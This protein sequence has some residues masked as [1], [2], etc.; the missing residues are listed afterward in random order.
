MQGIAGSRVR[1]S[2]VALLHPGIYDV[3]QPY[4]FPPWGI[5]C[6]RAALHRVEVDCHAFDLNGLDVETEVGRIATAF[7]PTVW[8]I[9]GKLG[10]GA[11]RL[12]RAID[13]IRALDHGAAIA[14]GGPLASTFPDISSPLWQGVDA[15]LLG[16]GESALPAWLGDGC[17]RGV[18]PPA[19]ADLDIGGLPSD[20][21]A[22]PKYVHPQWDWPNFTKAG[23]HVASARGCT[24]R[25]T[26]CYLSSHAV[27]PRLRF[28]SSP[29]LAAD[30][31]I[32]AKRTGAGGFY[33]VDDC[34][35]DSGNRLQS[36]S[37]EMN[38]RGNP[39]EFGC[40]VQLQDLDSPQVLEQMWQCGFRALYL[41]IEAASDRIRRRL[42]KGR[43]PTSVVSSV[44]RALDL[45]FVVRASIGIGWPTETRAEMEQTLGLI[46]AIDRLA[47]DA[48]K[49]LPLPGTPEWR[50]HSA[51][52]SLARTMSDVDLASADFSEFNDN[53][54]DLS[55]HELETV[56]AEMRSLEHERLS[57]YL[58]GRIL[59]QESA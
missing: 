56:W 24:R 55:D 23:I 5:L 29:R 47:F 54:T 2:R 11:L 59:K 20:W 36:F 58:A 22:L 57:R 39:Y 28:V 8:G 1:T 6:T 4:A 38:R 37:G 41:G 21:P 26:F 52:T 46:G 12:R 25:C 27:G 31:D 50:R 10:N 40:D 15:L 17:P 14:V 30:L 3:D 32:L 48:Y 49:F 51:A 35:L 53:Y 9:T 42:G 19:N 7:A 33:F 34:F 18:R 13:A 16:D 45:G 43:V 44:N